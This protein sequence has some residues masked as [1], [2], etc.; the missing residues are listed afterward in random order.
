MIVSPCGTLSIALVH[1]IKSCILGFILILELHFICICIFVPPQP[2]IYK[3]LL[4]QT[5]F[6]SPIDT[7]GA[8]MSIFSHFYRRRKLSILVFFPVNR[9]IRSCWCVSIVK[10]WY[11]VFFSRLTRMVYIHSMRVW[12]TVSVVRI[13][14]IF[15]GRKQFW[16]FWEKR[17]SRR[18]V[19]Q[20]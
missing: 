6:N 16:N 13:G 20:E 1:D 4:G 19:L 15:F 5:L 12:R 2:T 14:Y 9:F 11:I 10:N 17:S 7:T 18:T 3:I 8:L